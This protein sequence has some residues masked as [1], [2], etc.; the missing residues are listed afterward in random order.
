MS[1]DFLNTGVTRQE[2]YDRLFENADQGPVPYSTGM[3]S[4]LS[5]QTSGYNSSSQCS[6]PSTNFPRHLAKQSRSNSVSTASSISLVRDKQDEPQPS[7]DVPLQSEKYRSA[8][9]A[10]GARPP[11][12]AEQQ[13]PKTIVDWIRSEVSRDTIEGH[14][15]SIFKRDY[16]ASCIFCK[17]S[18]L[19]DFA[20]G[21]GR[22]C[23]SALVNALLALSLR[24][25]DCNEELTDHHIGACQVQETQ[26]QASSDGAV[27]SKH[28]ANSVFFFREADVC[29]GNSDLTKSLPDVQ[30]LGML[31]LY[32]VSLG[33]EAEAQNLAE[34]FLDAVTELCLQHISELDN[35]KDGY[36]Q[37]CATTY[38]GAVSLLR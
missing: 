13:T 9:W 3:S 12:R 22:Y 1:R 17:D 8:S 19:R 33:C 25:T 32:Q 36:Q 29:V 34:A 6:E 26:E 28:L 10:S 31:A 30:A 5:R 16:L 37:A 18:F 35:R 21:C 11:F 24:S 4:S 20:A 2:L 15:D 14:L 38:C 7:A 23:S 27:P